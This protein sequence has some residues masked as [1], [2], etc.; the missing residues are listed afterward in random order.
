MMNDPSSNKLI[1]EMNLKLR[2]DLTK[3]QQRQMAYMR[4]L[5]NWLRAG[6]GRAPGARAG[7]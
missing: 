4:P 7:G 3:A 1:V 2:E 6:E 5:Y